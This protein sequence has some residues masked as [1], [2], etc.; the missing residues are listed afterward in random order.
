MYE[1]ICDV[2][3]GAV[4]NPPALMNDFINDSWLQLENSCFVIVQTKV[5][6]GDGNSR[7]VKV[8]D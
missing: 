6:E 1:D 7:A 2:S 3:A 8:Q 5:C 4:N